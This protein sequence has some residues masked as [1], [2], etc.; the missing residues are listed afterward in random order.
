MIRILPSQRTP[1]EGHPAAGR[2]RVAELAE[3]LL[4]QHPTDAHVVAYAADES[5]TGDRRLVQAS[6]A[7]G[8]RPR[9]VLGL[10]D[11]DSP[12]EHRGEDGEA[13]PAWR[14]EQAARVDRLRVDVPGLVEYETRKGYRLVGLLPEPVVIAS[15]ADA[16]R[17]RASYLRRL[18]VL[19]REYGIVGDAACSDWTRLYR[20]PHATRTPAQ[21]PE[22]RPLRG[23]PHR[24]GAW[25]ALVDAPEALAAD[26]ATLRATWGDRVA[27]HVAPAPPA[28]PRAPR[29]RATVAPAIAADLGRLYGAARAVAEALA[30]LPR[31]LGERHD[32][33]LA[34]VGA[35]V[36][37]GWT[38]AAVRRLMGDV[39]DALGDARDEVAS[40][41]NSTLR[42]RDAQLP[43]TGLATLRALAPRAAEALRTCETPAER[44]RRALGAIPQPAELTPDEA[45]RELAGALREAREAR[46][47]SVLAVT[48]GAGKT[49]AACEDARDAARAGRRT[50]ILA[51]SHAVAAETVDRLRAWGVAAAHLRGVLSVV[52]GEG[53]PVCRHAESAEAL[54]SA[55]VGTVSTMCDG[56]GYATRT[57]RGQRRL[58]LYKGG[59]PK[60]VGPACEHR[61]RCEAYKVRRRE[62]EALADAQVL[63]TVHA[64]AD[65]AHRWLAEA[66]EGALAVIDEA[67]ELLVAS[68]LTA[69]EL[70]AA[71]EAIG[72]RRSAVT[73][74]E[75]WR[76]D[77]LRAAARGLSA[78]PEGASVAQ[79]LRAGLAV[80][81]GSL[82]ATLP[83][84]DAVTDLLA[85]WARD[86]GQTRTGRPR[87]QIAP[88]P[89][90][91]VV[92]EAR[93]RAG[94]PPQVVDA[95]R[96][97][98]LVARA[99]AAELAGGPSCAS[100]VGTREHGE[101]GGA[102]ELRLTATAAP[103]RALLADA[104]VG[105][106]V[107]DAT[108]PPS[109]ALLAAAAG[110]PVET[111]ATRTIAV[112][113]GAPVE[114]IY[115]PWSHASRR[116]CLPGG[117]P[118][119]TE[120]RGPLREGLR[121]AAEGLPRGA[122]L[123]AVTWQVVTRAIAA[124]DADAELR[125]EL[126]ELAERGI[127]VEWAHYGATRG[128]DRWRDVDAVVAVGTPWPDESAVAQVVAASG[129]PAEG[130]R[131][132]A[133][134]L[135]RAELAQV[136]GRLRAPRR[137]RDARVVVVASVTPL[138]ADARWQVRELAAG[139][140][141]RA[142]AVPEGVTH[143]AAAAAAGVSRST[144]KRR[145]REAREAEGGGSKPVTE[146]YVTGCEPPPSRGCHDTN[147]RKIGLF[148]RRP[149]E[150][151][152]PDP[153]LGD[154][155]LVARAAPVP[156]PEARASSG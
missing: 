29:S 103:L 87:R 77:V 120:L 115:V 131:E 65:D 135:A 38:A 76:A 74:A 108:A 61:S 104:S 73:R 79:V 36:D 132:C 96:V 129:L 27:A 41:I 60:R 83:D 94:V 144:I 140:P 133:R 72:A 153:P 15:D 2:L 26:V 13:S 85:R 148:E 155:P 81:E 56:D 19:A 55:G 75:A 78:A 125:A 71:A 3:A 39:A 91:R 44:A 51:C 141:P 86:S 97:A 92:D 150:P 112:R 117:V 111:V 37:A 5:P 32:A 80:A 10:V 18:A 14:A 105:R 46:T 68:A 102:R 151:D 25:P 67:P 57:P 16:A 22:H 134:H 119:W 35:L 114:R 126:A 40:A 147:R 122:R 42:R 123:L 145:R 59:A 139:R 106:V 47:L 152:T 34:C 12:Q 146:A 118:E 101:G 130:T 110:V 58:T 45:S 4:A 62:R 23:D 53:R 43:F 50:A 21:G 8:A 24:L 70:A 136:I 90:R 154:A 143:A 98:G 52:D 127:T 17:W 20:L 113:D 48:T 116:A 109:A 100:A 137:T 149:L 66:P 6:I 99:L 1:G 95:I 124:S 30:E 88:R 93:R 49:H 121:L 54:A 128:V 142:V 63:V 7:R 84:D 64:L 31:G 9:M 89:A 69:A 156:V 107:L 138:G 11:V 82:V 28:A 33:L